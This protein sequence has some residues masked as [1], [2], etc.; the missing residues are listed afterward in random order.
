LIYSQLFFYSLYF[1]KS[2]S[3]SLARHFMISLQDLSTFTFSY[4]VV[5][6]SNHFPDGVQ[7]LNLE[8]PELTVPT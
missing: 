6:S 5:S 7:T 2:T 3:V 8:A 1:T 4:W